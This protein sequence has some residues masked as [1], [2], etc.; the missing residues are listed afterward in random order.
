MDLKVRLETNLAI[1]KLDNLSLCEFTNLD[2]QRHHI[3]T[4][5][6][7]LYNTEV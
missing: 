5:I 7:N 1:K 2:I 6:L 4:D 3:I